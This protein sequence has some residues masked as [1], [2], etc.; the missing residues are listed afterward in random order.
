MRVGWLEGPEVAIQTGVASQ[1]DTA[2]LLSGVKAWRG[3]AANTGEAGI[4]QATLMNADLMVVR[5]AQ[6]KLVGVASYTIAADNSLRVG[7]LATDPT[8]AG[9]GRRTMRELAGIASQE[10]RGMKLLSTPEAQGF[11][12]RLG[13]TA[14]GKLYGFTP[15]EAAAFASGLTGATA[16]G[17]QT[18]LGTGGGRRV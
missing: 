1:F 11:Y 15:E 2:A 14:T 8:S 7:Y 12:E 4:K 5:D 10:G 3:M 18:Q 13:M 16:F 17:G 6:G 9:V